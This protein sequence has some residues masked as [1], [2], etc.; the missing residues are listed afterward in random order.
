MFSSV[1]ALG[2]LVGTAMA[3]TVLW[4]GR[5]NDM[6]SSTDLN[7]WSFSNEVG[8]YQYYIHGTGPVTDYVNLDSTYKNPA[9]SSSKQGV[10]ITLDQ[11]AVWNN[12][13]MLR[14]ELIPQTSAAINK[15]KVYYHFSMQHTGVNPPSQY[16]E[17][18]VC[19][20]E[21]HFTEMKYG[22]ISGEQATSDNRLQ[23]M[24]GGVGKWETNFTAGEWH[25]VA[26]EIDFDASTVAYYHSTG[27]EDLTL[28]AGPFSASTSSNGADWHLGVLRL[29]S[30]TGRSDTAAEDWHF[31]GVYIES[32]DLTTS[33]SGPGGAASSGSASVAP[34][35]AAAV[36]AT[37][38]ADYASSS[39]AAAAAAAVSTSSA[40]EVAAT[41][42]SAYSSSA[43]ASTVFAASTV[44]LSPV[45]VSTESTASSAATAVSDYGSV[46]AAATSSSEAASI[47]TSASSAAPVETESIYS[48]SLASTYGYTSVPT[49]LATV[50]STSS[51]SAAAAVTTSEASA[52]TTAS[53]PY[54]PTTVSAF[55]SALISNSIDTTVVSGTQV[56][57]FLPS[58]S[59]AAAAAVPTS[60]ELPSG[61]GSVPAATSST[62]AAPAETGA[63]E[64]VCHIEYVYED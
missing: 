53:V 33:V 37:S 17:H 14:T 35:T 41:G 9:D 10:K 44:T 63:G 58:T 43:A 45:P 46:S 7:N 8:P 61:Y 60:S 51:S 42:L 55:T 4:D 6:T 20:F 39:S 57:S 22:L 27:A 56:S 48:F 18:Q 2:A 62:P 34:S 12:D 29:A 49:T 24:V 30:S 21:S 25:N 31:S 52:P 26:Y 36:E 19:F 1:A 23:W 64:G 15:G 59:T 32:G 54:L 47:P 11:T 16:E 5:F 13:G 38:L 28:T 3:G 40:V 50:V